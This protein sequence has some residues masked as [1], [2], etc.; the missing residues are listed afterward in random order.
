MEDNDFLH[1]HRTK[2]ES[3][4]KLHAV[5]QN[6]RGLFEQD[7]WKPEHTERLKEK[8]RNKMHR[9]RLQIEK[10]RLNAF[11][12]DFQPFKEALEILPLHTHEKAFRAFVSH[13]GKDKV[14]ELV[15]RL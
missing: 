12:D 1:H 2:E 9:I 14:E 7:N 3:S 10:T 11:R 8:V 13:I 6:L 4:Q 5:T 15:S